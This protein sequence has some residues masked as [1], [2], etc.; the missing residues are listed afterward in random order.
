M[1]VPAFID[2]AQIELVLCDADG[3]LFASEEPAFEASAEVTNLMLAELDIPLRYTPE[4]LRLTTTG[5]NFRTTAREL[6]AE[7]GQVIDEDSLEDWVAEER[8][9]VTGHLLDVLRPVPG[10]VVP[11]VSM[12]RRRRLAV[13]SSSAMSRVDASLA[14][15]GLHGL[16]ALDA[17]FSAEDSLAEPTSKPDPAIYRMAGMRMAADPETTIAVEDSV[18]GAASAIAAGFPTVG[19]VMF[20]PP[21]E[22]EER[23]AELE[24]IGVDGWVSSWRE[25]ERWL[26]GE[27]RKPAAR[28]A[29]AVT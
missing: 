11:L 24:S 16:F 26:H 4:E 20:V 21:E 18:P 6:L 29:E 15:A 23:I 2:P 28:I 8:R 7:H 13:V 19:Q 25:L 9:A 10:V 12:S 1:A 22:R 3:C 14:A 5:K 17:R 27:T